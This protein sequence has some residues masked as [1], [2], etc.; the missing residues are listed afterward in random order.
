MAE[1]LKKSTLFSYSLTDIPIV[2]GLFPVGV[3]LPRYYSNDVGMGLA[4]VGTIM[5]AVGIFDVFTDPLMAT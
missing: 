3:F 5:L 4:M 1:R 2:M